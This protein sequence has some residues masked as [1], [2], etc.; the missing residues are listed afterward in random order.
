MLS[1]NNTTIDIAKVFPAYMSPFFNYLFMPG[2]LNLVTV[3]VLVITFLFVL[4]S[5]FLYFFR[6]QK[7]LKDTYMYLEVKPTDKT[8]KSPLSTNQLFV[9]LHSL[10]KQN[11][12]FE[13]LINLKR[14]ISLELVSTKEEGIRYI[15]R[16]LEKDVPMVKKTLLAYLPG[17]EIE[18]VADYL[19]GNLSDKNYLGVKELM[20]TKPY[21]YPLQDQ[22]VLN[23][24]D[25]IVYYSLHD[26][27]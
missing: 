1:T 13:R 27:T 26:Q 15:L 8:L 11:S 23:Q 9:L 10:G 19:V 25:P 17:I 16:V 24:Y 6:L 7:T 22:S 4:L 21:V 5:V 2:F 18:E 14:N 12:T 3:S 20:L